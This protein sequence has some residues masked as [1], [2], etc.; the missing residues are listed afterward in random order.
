MFYGKQYTI[1]IQSEVGEGTSICIPIPIEQNQNK[2]S[3]ENPGGK[4]DFD[5]NSRWW[6]ID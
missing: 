4:Y 3:W 6:K 5:C 1:Q 2:N